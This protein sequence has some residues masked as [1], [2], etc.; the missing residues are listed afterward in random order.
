[1]N[2]QATRLHRILRRAATIAVMAA[3]PLAVLPAHA[4]TY[5]A[6]LQDIRATLGMVPDF[7]AKLP[8]AALPG[9]WSAYKGLYGPNTQLPPKY[10]SLISL[11]V[12][13]QIPCEY[14]VAMDTADARRAGASDQE[15][16]EAIT[17][18][19][20]TRQWSAIFYGQQ[21]DLKKFKRD[22]GGEK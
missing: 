17:V 19:G 21:V 16:S 18:A 13:A 5:D 1:M 20:M 7:M 11:A 8:P 10:R 3:A 9:I 4:Q 6:T 15:I 14:C 2:R 12:A 22:F